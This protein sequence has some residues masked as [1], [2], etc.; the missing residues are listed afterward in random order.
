[1]FGSIWDDIKR[2]FSY[3]NMVNRLIIINVVVFVAV[4]LLWV[5][6]RLGN[7]GVTPAIYGK[8]IQFFEFSSD[9]KHN[10]LHP[11]TFIT[12]TFLHEGFMHIAFNMLFF[13]WFGRIVGDLIGDGRVFPLYLLGGIVGNLIFFISVKIFGYGAP[14]VADPALDAPAVIHYALGASAAVMAFI[15]A[16]GFIAPNF[17]IHLPLLGAIKLKFIV[18]AWILYDLVGVAGN[19]NTGGHFAHLGGAFMG[20]FFVAQLH[21]GNDLSIPLNRFFRRLRTLFTGMKSEPPP[22]RQSRRVYSN[23]APQKE[24]FKNKNTAKGLSHQEQLDAILDKISQSG[25]ESL[26]KEEMEF[27]FNASNK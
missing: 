2:E 18:G 6:L 14:E 9:W 13:Y 25:Y 21:K 4:C 15:V 10:L 22:R 26:S 19:I 20:W 3:G 5:I 27:L 16:S 7:A 11:W 12:N 1:M 17:L 24:N 8:I 23:P